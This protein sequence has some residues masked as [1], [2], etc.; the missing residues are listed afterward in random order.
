MLREQRQLKTVKVQTLPG[1]V[2]ARLVRR[3]LDGEFQDSSAPSE[4]EISRE[5]GL[6][7]SVARETF[8]L[9]ASLDIIDV[10]QG[11]RNA[12]R[13]MAEWDYLNPLLAEW[14][15][16]EHVDELLKELHEARL[17]LE[18]ELAAK[19]ADAISD[20]AL[21]QLRT[22]LERMSALE[23]NPDDYLEVDLAFHMAI[24]RAANNRILDR[25]MY[26]A[27]WLLTASRQVTNVG[28]KALPTATSAHAAVFAAIEAR[29]PEAARL[30][31]RGHLQANFPILAANEQRAKGVRDAAG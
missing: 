2:A 1:Q 15:P 26:S 25:I 19:A 3:I 17:L 30:A 29:D 21:G 11:R 18:P 12:V 13:P 28:S 14:L 4:M 6:S 20:E 16:E 24:C 10:A 7:R 9:L 22:E 23:A 31:M 8:K 27:R 5:Y